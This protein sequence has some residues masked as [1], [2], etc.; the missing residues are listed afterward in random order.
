MSTGYAK[1]ARDQ[2]QIVSQAILMASPE[3][4]AEIR[5]MLIDLAKASVDA[6]VRSRMYNSGPIVLEPYA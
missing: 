5:K 6:E 4:V 3:E 1:Y 2:L